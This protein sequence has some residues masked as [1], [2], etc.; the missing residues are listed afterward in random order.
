MMQGPAAE[1]RGCLGK[2]G[3]A[4]SPSAALC[5]WGFRPPSYVVS[6]P[7]IRESTPQSRSLRPHNR[8]CDTFL[9]LLGD[10]GRAS[11][12]P[13]YRLGRVVTPAS[14]RAV[15]PAS[16]MDHPAARVLHESPELQTLLRVSFLVLG[17]SWA[18]AP[19]QSRDRTFGLRPISARPIVHGRSGT[20]R[21]PAE[22]FLCGCICDALASAGQTP[23]DTSAWTSGPASPPT[24]GASKGVGG[25]V[26]KAVRRIGP[27]ASVGG[28]C[29]ADTVQTG[30]SGGRR[31]T[32]TRRSKDGRGGRDSRHGRT[33]WCRAR[34][35]V[36][37]R[38]AR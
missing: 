23:R 2:V 25:G 30:P 1:W 8:A 33:V 21:W 31:R 37:T 3:T 16:R 14:A 26:T 13:Q 28:L 32:A 11:R 38:R 27:H 17:Q 12:L 20:L 22:I 4:H 24:S 5:C 36:S 34:V 15:N 18:F 19:V 7:K 6:H 29:G 35:G 9:C 10:A